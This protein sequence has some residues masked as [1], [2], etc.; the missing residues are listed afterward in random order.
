MAFWTP[1]LFHCINRLGDTCLRPALCCAAL[2]RLQ[3]CRRQSN[4]GAVA[5]TASLSASARRDLHAGRRRDGYATCSEPPPG[6]RPWSPRDRLILALAETTTGLPFRAANAARVRARWRDKSN[7]RQADGTPFGSSPSPDRLERQR[8]PLAGRACRQEAAAV[9]LRCLALPGTN[10][11]PGV[12]RS[13]Q[14]RR[15]SRFRVRR[16]R[17]SQPVARASRRMSASA[18]VLRAVR[19]QRRASPKRFSNTAPR[20]LRR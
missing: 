19:V 20:A 4:A 1:P 13:A 14:R 8:R 2:N 16:L 17:A 7:C 10:R 9:S 15:P 11:Y 18:E 5:E 6:L 3:G 12:A